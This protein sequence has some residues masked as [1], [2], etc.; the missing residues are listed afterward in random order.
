MLVSWRIVAFHLPYKAVNMIDFITNKYVIAIA[1]YT[2]E[3]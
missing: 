2:F 1:Y 3:M